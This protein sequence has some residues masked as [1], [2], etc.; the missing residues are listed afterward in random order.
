MA[1]SE[2]VLKLRSGGRLQAPLA[3]QRAEDFKLSA[4]GAVDPDDDKLELIQR[5]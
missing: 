4:A 2:V 5:G 1:S 3:N